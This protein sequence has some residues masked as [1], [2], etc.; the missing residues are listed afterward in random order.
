MIPEQVSEGSA[1]GKGHRTRT[2]ATLAYTADK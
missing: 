2:K 1:L